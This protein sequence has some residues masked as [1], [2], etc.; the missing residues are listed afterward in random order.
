VVGAPFPA[1]VVRAAVDGARR[2][3]ARMHPRRRLRRAPLLPRRR[4]HAE[5]RAVVHRGRRQVVAVSNEP[6][7]YVYSGAAS[8]SC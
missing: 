4:P 1:P 8:I 5:A 2:P 7:Y 6:T 3:R